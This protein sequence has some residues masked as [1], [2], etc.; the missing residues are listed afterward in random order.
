MKI[1]KSRLEQIVNEEIQR[2]KLINK[3]MKESLNETDWRDTGSGGYHKPQA[4]AGPYAPEKGV[5]DPTSG[6]PMGMDQEATGGNPEVAAETAMAAAVDA[7]DQAAFYKAVD[8][9]LAL[10]YTMEE[11]ENIVS[12]LGDQP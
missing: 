5:E 6:L 10:D 9:L 1:K 2:F 4:D 11:I 8:D 3:T 12:S 7:G